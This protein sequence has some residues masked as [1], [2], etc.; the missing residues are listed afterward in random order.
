MNIYLSELNAPRPSLVSCDRVERL[1]VGF[2]KHNAGD[3]TG[4]MMMAYGVTEG[5]GFLVSS[6][7]Q[8]QLRGGN[9][10]SCLCACLLASLRRSFI[11]H[12]ASFS[13]QIHL[14][15]AIFYEK[16]KEDNTK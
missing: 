6:S 15:N 11:S 5:N 3:M 1:R 2:E 14:L 10:L 12:R 16:T 9:D 8:M 7:L 13:G 4:M